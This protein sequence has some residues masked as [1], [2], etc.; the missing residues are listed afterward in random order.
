VRNKNVF[1]DLGF[2]REE[3]AALEMKAALH[4]VILRQAKHYKQAQLQSLLGESQPR[5]SDLLTGKISKFSLETLVE[6]AEALN[7]RP[8]IKTHKPVVALQAARAAS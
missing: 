1:D 7:L 2:S 3:A 4:S 6:Y 8:E 5:V